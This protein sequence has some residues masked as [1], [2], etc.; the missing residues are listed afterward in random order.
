M[1]IG[2][3]RVSA[4]ERSAAYACDDLIPPPSLSMFRAIDV[5]APPSIVFR[6]LCQLKVAPYSY[7][8]LDNGGHRS[9][10]ELT[11]GADD[12]E[13][14]QRYVLGRIVSFERDAHITCRTT[15]GKEG[16]YGP[17][18]VTY[19]V[20]TGDGGGC[21]I[22][23]KAVMGTAGRLGSL[24]ARLLS[25]ADVPMA[26]MQLITLKKLAEGDAALAASGTS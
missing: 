6:W 23:M 17:V 21:R 10:R 2:V 13:A 1:G 11:P 4:A 8:R 9:P 14:G 20:R 5:A 16:L 12:L 26:R 3:L 25:A 19:A 24:R 22:V 7:D 18:A 15:P